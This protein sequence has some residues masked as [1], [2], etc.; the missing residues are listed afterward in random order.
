[1]SM[2]SEFGAFSDAGNA[3]PF[4]GGTLSP[5]LDDSLNYFSL[6]DNEDAS[7]NLNLESPP[8]PQLETILNDLYPSRLGGSPEVHPPNDR[9]FDTVL[10][11]LSQ[12]LMEENMVEKPCVFQDSLAPQAADRP[13][14][15]E[16][17]E[18]YSQHPIVNPYVESPGDTSS[19]FTSEHSGSTSTTNSVDPIWILGL[20]GNESSLIQTPIDNFIQ[21]STASQK[22]LSTLGYLGSTGNRSVNSCL[23]VPLDPNVLSQRESMVQFQKGVE[24]ASK[25]LP[26]NNNIVIDLRNMTFPDESNEAP[27]LVVKRE[28]EDSPDGSRGRKVHDR[29][30]DDFVDGRSSKQ[31]A[32]FVQESELSEMFDKVLLCIPGTLE[33][34]HPMKL[35]LQKEGGQRLEQNGQLQGSNGGGKGHLEM[36]GPNKNVVDLTNLLILCAQA[37]SL[38]D[39]TTADEFLKRIR[40]HASPL[41]HGSQRL[42]HYFSNALEARLAGTGSQ[43]YA[44]LP[45][46]RITAAEA[47]QAYQVYIAS[48]PFISIGFSV[49]TILKA[50]EKAKKLHIVDFGILYGFQWPILIQRLSERPGGPPKLCITGID[51]PLPGFRPAERAEATGRR[52]AKY[53]ERFNV[54]FEYH[55]I[56]QKWETIKLEDLRISGDGVVAVHC[57]YWFRYLLDETIVVDCPR[58]AVLN[59]IRDINPDIFVNAS[60]NGSFNLPFFITRFREALF[61][62]STLF[63]MF[64][65]NIPRDQPGRLMF[66]REFFG[67][68]IMNAVACEGTERV[69]RPE[70]YKQWQVRIMKAGFKPLPLDPE[71]IEKLRIKVQTFYHKDFCID[72]DGHWALEGWKGRIAFASSAWVPS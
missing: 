48:C 29:E 39:R 70:T 16:L 8:S 59:F 25:F 62:F 67:R 71:L 30:N 27:A 34:H 45:T 51:L 19:G 43:I 14:Y 1:M 28:R 20:S 7:R 32:V 26:K 18:K 17:G 42:A 2:D 53:C 52:L 41:G 21:Q 44:A 24:E 5:G 63:D 55:A 11:Y 69:E 68:S 22:S 47:I 31:S 15:D 61:H 12:M 64:D 50:A 3:H 46:Q 36:Q 13:F 49:H 23:D 56:A 9:D 10:K 6:F 4:V 38:D 65:A 35:E 66:E 54:P 37:T 57:S 58:N 72:V 60:V 33:A 40:Q